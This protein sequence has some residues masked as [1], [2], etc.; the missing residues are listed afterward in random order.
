VHDPLGG[1]NR[2]IQ[3]LFSGRVGQYR[4]KLG[5]FLQLRT[6]QIALQ[7]LGANHDFIRRRRFHFG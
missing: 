2:E 3:H 4:I 7:L 6:L 1:I 5:R